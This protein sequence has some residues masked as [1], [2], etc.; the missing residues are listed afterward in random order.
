MAPSLPRIQPGAAVSGPLAESWH[1][2]RTGQLRRAAS[3]LAAAGRRDLDEEQRVEHAA[4]LLTCRLASG[5]LPA[6]RTSA[7]LLEPALA[8]ADRPGVLA[9]LGHGELA[10][11]S[12]EHE[13]A[14]HHFDSAGELAGADEVADP[15]W[16]AGAALA[17]VRLGRR[18]QATDLARQ[19]LDLAEQIGTPRLLAIALRTVAT[20][21]ASADAPSSLHRA[22]VLA[23][24]AGDRRLAAQV[25]TD[26]A[27]LM[28]LLSS[29]GAGSPVPLLRDAED[30]AV[31]EGLWPLHGRVSRLLERAGERPRPLRQ[32]AV[33][34]LTD[35]EHRVARLA[36]R[37]LTNRQ[38][39]DHLGVTVK[40]VEW[41]LS[42]TYRKLGI[43]SRDDLASLLDDTGRVSVSA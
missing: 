23:V 35:G 19:L 15:P 6:A 25:A 38:I 14:L 8:S 16:R 31:Q 13:R 18:R 17:L 11:A 39:A 41:H 37:G 26:L 42:R 21:D 5:D 12:G 10:A 43:A 32:D 20:V 34:L 29:P 3:E 22:R 28:L 4:L 1:L 9:R 27:G 40:G 30:Y 33:A 2:V 7:A 24:A 36:A